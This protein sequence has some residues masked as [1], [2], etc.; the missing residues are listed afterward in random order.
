[1]LI[2]DPIYQ[3]IKIQDQVLIDLIN[4]PSLERLK[5]ISQGGLPAKYSPRE[6]YSRYEHSVGVMIL[7][8]LLNASIEEQVAGLLHDIA[9]LSFS[10]LSEWV[11]AGN[12][13]EDFSEN[14]TQKIIL[15]SEIVD[16]LT[17][18]GI[19]VDKIINF[20]KFKLLEQPIPFLCADRLDY[21]LRDTYRYI[22]QTLAKIVVRNLAVE[23]EKI[24]INDPSIALKFA[25]KFL[26]LQTHIYAGFDTVLRYYLL[27]NLL[28]ENV[29]KKRLNLEDFYQSEETIL[30]KLDK[31]LDEKNK[32][33]LCLLENK[34]LKKLKGRYQTNIK[35]KFRY[36]N[37]LVRNGSSISPLTT[38]F[39]FFE[40]EIAKHRAINEQGINI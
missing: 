38:V 4:C 36:I 5:N 32:Q 40:K 7:L 34:N 39:P 18:H 13:A 25:K 24:I 29:D 26:K 23:D 11:F 3:N 16:I 30:S 21:G 14:L 2:T 6:S 9:H 22:D 10:H 20:K 31:L 8:K 1:M 33:Q 15:E 27:A 12:Y 37:P 35:K 19:N 28:K 17:S